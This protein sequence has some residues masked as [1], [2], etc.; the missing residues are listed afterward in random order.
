MTSFAIITVAEGL[1]I[2]AF[3]AALVIGIKVVNF[4]ID[5][6]SRFLTLLSF[7]FKI[8]SQKEG[9]TF[10][11]FLMGIPIIITRRYEYNLVVLK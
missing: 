6:N 3:F 5:I 2:I 4:I 10:K 9:R 11:Y 8:Q 1:T 7:T